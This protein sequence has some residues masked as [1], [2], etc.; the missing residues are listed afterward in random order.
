LAH[1]VVQV[2][3]ENGLPVMISEDEITCEIQGPIRLLGL[4]ASNNSDMG[5]YRDNKQRAFHGRLLAYV[6]TTGTSG[7]ATLKFTAPWL[8]SAEIKLIIQ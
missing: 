7:E 8:K 2:V 6:Q 5:N 1:V 4:E 3:D